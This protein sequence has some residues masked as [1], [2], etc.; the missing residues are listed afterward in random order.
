MTTTITTERLEEILAALPEELGITGTP[1]CAG[2]CPM[3]RYIASEF[4]IT[5]TRDG[6]AFGDGVT[7]FENACVRSGDE[8]A[9]VLAPRHL[10]EFAVRFDLGRYPAL[11]SA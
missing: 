9:K 8:F 10:Y 1:V 7:F 2:L 5:T 11:V 6:A 4:G 3:S